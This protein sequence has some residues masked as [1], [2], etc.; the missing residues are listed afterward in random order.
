MAYPSV[1]H[2]FLDA[3]TIV[4][5]QFNTNF[6]DLINGLSDGTKDLNISALTCAGNAAFNG[7]VTL[8]NASGDD[9]TVTG[10]LASSIPIKTTYSYDIG[11]ATLGLKKVYFGSDDSAARSTYIEAGTPASSFGL[12][13]P[14]AD[15]AAKD[16]LQT[17]GA[18]Q[19]A[20]VGAPGITSKTANYTGTTADKRIHYDTSSG[21]CTHTM[22]SASGNAGRT[23]IIRKTT[24]DGNTV[25][26]E[27]KVLNRINEEIEFVSD[28]TNWLIKN[29][30]RPLM[31]ICKA[32]GVSSTVIPSSG[33][34]K[35]L[36]F[37]TVASNP[38]SLM[39]GLTTTN[40]D[41][42]LGATYWT[43]P[44]SGDFRFNC[45]IASEDADLD[46]S[47]SLTLR[48]VYNGALSEYSSNF[49]Y[50]T[51]ATPRAECIIV[52]EWTGINKGDTIE[53]AAQ[54][55]S[56][57]DVTLRTGVA[58]SYIVITEIPTNK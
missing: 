29:W 40:S 42:S 45:R 1:T 17:D 25:T 15:G 31:K 56:G 48:L 19:L 49:V 30:Y 28:G 47:E 21:N 14:D 4:A 39:S 20:F 5:S 41:A 58:E 46:V 18:G 27:S 44:W 16:Y 57:G 35:Y 8:G 22:Y 36:S 7:N 10:S 11:S 37:Q 52:S 50:A 6:T 9:V 55:N 13:L 12:K 2:T 43:A 33:A 34:Y 26:V 38:D 51:V 23:V 53:F 24:S 32:T 54:T 3:T